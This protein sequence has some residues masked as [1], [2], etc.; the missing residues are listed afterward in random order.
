MGFQKWLLELLHS[1]EA[2]FGTFAASWS[3]AGLTAIPFP[4][5]RLFPSHL[6]MCYRKWG[7][8]TKIKRHSA[9]NS[10][11]LT[12]LYIPTCGSEGPAPK[13]A[14]E[15]PLLQTNWAR[16]PSTSL[17][18]HHLNQNSLP[19]PLL[20]SDT[21]NKSSIEQIPHLLHALPA[22]EDSHL[23]LGRSRKHTRA[24]LSLLGGA[25]GPER[26]SSHQKHH[27]SQI[28]QAFLAWE[29]SGVCVTPQTIQ[30]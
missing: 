4:S 8:F 2:S 28:C 16:K 30:H 21:G 5:C 15:V 3:T 7:F 29:L 18:E 9:T 23:W 6:S 13:K 26:A 22:G 12:A 10:E 25:V 27:C 11:S 20:P 1:F 24:S 17:C 19:P 14:Q